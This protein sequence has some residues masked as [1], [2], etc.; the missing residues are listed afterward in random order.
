MII[1]VL[2]CALQVAHAGTKKDLTNWTDGGSDYKDGAYAYDEKWYE[3][4][5]SDEY[6]ISTPEEMGAFAKAAET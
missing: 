5:T 4:T 2:F 6:T 1:S 3:N